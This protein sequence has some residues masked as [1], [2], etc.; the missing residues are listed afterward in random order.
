MVSQYSI[1]GLEPKE[2]FKPESLEE[3][4][5]ILKDAN[6]KNKALAPICY[7]TKLNLGNPLKR[8]DYLLILSELKNLVEYAP[9]D[10]Y[11]TVQCGMKLKDLQEI[12]KR[13]NQHIPLDPPYY[14][15]ASIGGIISTNSFGPKRLRYG[16]LRDMLLGLKI[17]TAEGKIIRAGGKVVKNVAGYD[18]VKLYIGSL[19]TLG[20]IAE[21]TFRVYPLPEKLV[22]LIVKLKDYREAMSLKERVQDSYLLPCALDMI[23]PSLASSLNLDGSYYLLVRFDGLEVDVNRE[24][25]DAL[26]LFKKGGFYDV[27]VIE[28]DEDLWDKL[29][30]YPQR[31][32]EKESF[33]SLKVGILSTDLPLLM[34][35][36]E[37]YNLKPLINYHLGLGLGR[38]FLI[39]AEDYNVLG[40]VIDALREELYSKK[41]YL[42]IEHSPKELKKY[43]NVW[44]KLREDF[45]LM[46]GLKEAL[47]PKGILNPGRFVGGI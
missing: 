4:S 31:I 28:K 44:G 20:V 21:A 35:L 6:E 41:G 23:N 10:L 1:E 25:R 42:V 5:L 33:V 18:L 29:I 13:K 36:M 19:G 12:L 2:I 30:N 16:S 11:V 26:D 45:P 24:V 7:G 9:S 15:K 32:K 47:D 17:V 22:T 14:D 40:K 27:K 38:M 37:E 8:L 34:R 43:T 39:D 46:K 3:V